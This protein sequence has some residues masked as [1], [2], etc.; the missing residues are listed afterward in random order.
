ME[1]EKWVSLIKKWAFDPKE[2]EIRVRWLM[3][4]CH[5][6]SKGQNTTKVSPQFVVRRFNRKLIGGRKVGVTHEKMGI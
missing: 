6:I 3:K 2:G 5:V 1:E 4:N